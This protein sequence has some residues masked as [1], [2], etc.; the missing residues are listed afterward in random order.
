MSINLKINDLSYPC[1]TRAR[2]KEAAL[3]LLNNVKNSPTI[4]DLN[5][6]EFLSFSFLDELVF[7]LAA[8][9][10]IHNVVFSF[11]DQKIKEKLERVAAIRGAEIIYQTSKQKPRGLI[12]KASV[13]RK[14]EFVPSKELLKL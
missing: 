1:V 8:S 12:P 6:A 7:W 5:D 4:L 11:D 3:K 9:A 10:N 14:A 13:G 2:G